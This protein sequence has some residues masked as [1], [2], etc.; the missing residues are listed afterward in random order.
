MSLA[1]E[2]ERGQLI[3]RCRHPDPHMVVL[4]GHWTLTDVFECGH[5]WKPILD[6]PDKW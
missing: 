6:C 1:T 2:R 3:C 5:C 4:F